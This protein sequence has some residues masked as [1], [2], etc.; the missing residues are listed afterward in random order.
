MFQYWVEF[1]ES[2]ELT[3]NYMQ[4]SDYVETKDAQ[5]TRELQ[6]LT[7]DKP[8]A[9]EGIPNGEPGAPPALG[10]QKPQAEQEVKARSFQNTFVHMSMQDPLSE[11]PKSM[12]CILS[13][14]AKLREI[15]E[16]V[17]GEVDKTQL[18]VNK[19]EQ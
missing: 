11:L 9:F 16:S 14:S 2:G 8:F 1:E 5:N 10:D 12:E 6:K 19:C 13:K 3:K 15:E 7:A 18:A 4:R 17:R